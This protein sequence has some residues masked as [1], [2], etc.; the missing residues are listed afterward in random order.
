MRAF[1]LVFLSALFACRHAQPAPA[2]RAVEGS[3][4]PAEQALRPWTGCFSANAEG[5]NAGVTGVPL[6]FELTD[7]PKNA[8]SDAPTLYAV[9]SRE[10]NVPEEN[11]ELLE[12]MW[13]WRPVDGGLRVTFS[14]G[15]FGT[16][17]EA[18][19]SG[20]GSFAGIARSISD[21]ASST[22]QGAK[23]RLRR[24]PCR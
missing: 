18:Y 10:E 22:D 21:V 5:A 7:E 2:I 24:V 12:R 13:R 6:V 11:R 4:S 8:A 1:L 23:V 16:A 19:P 9:R 17:I 14:N 3:A 15:L 20:D